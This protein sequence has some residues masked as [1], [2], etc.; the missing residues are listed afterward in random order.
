MTT[1]P[2]VSL[3]GRAVQYDNNFLYLHGRQVG[4][5]PLN[6]GAD[7]WFVDSSVD[8]SSGGD[9]DHAFGTLDE[10]INAASEYDQIIV[11]PG[12]SESLDAAA[13]VDVDVNGIQ[14]IGLGTGSNQPRFEFDDTAATF[15]VNADDIVLDNL[16]FR[17]DESG[18]VIG[19]DVKDGADDLKI[20]NCRFSAETLTTD[21]FNDAVF[22]TTS[23]RFEIAGCTFDMDQAAA[24]SAIHIVGACLGCNIHDNV[25]LG[26][27]AVGC[28]EGVT[29][30]AEQ[31]LIQNNTLVN[32]VHGGLNAV[33]CISLFT[34]TTGF[35][36]GNSLYTAVTNAVTAAISADGCFLARNTVSTT[37]ETPPVEAELLGRGRLEVTAVASVEVNDEGE[38]T[39]FVVNGPVDLY[40]LFGV[41][42]TA[43]D[44]TEEISLTTE[45]GT[46]LMALGEVHTATAAGDV[47]FAATVGAAP[48]V[49]E[50]GTAEQHLF[51]DPVRIT[52]DEDGIDMLAEGDVDGGGEA[53]LYC[54]WSPVVAGA[55]VATS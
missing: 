43:A 39:P 23:D 2:R 17:A 1:H 55:E 24:Q 20:L 11:M 3:H 6:K 51:T 14:I 25:V 45:S 27:Y 37:A 41:M 36:Q 54:V 31:V 28:I 22:I 32:G 5:P 8:G 26:D 35:I 52:G 7:R 19:I 13:D 10:A 33:A 48:T 53:T 47:F 16:H 15:E 18:V 44:E 30:A 4:L 38:G 49:D 21:E 50:I 46:T 42:T 29:A 9:P 40:G 34:G 12:H